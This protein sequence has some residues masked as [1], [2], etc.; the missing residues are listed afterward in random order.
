MPLH[1]IYSPVGTLSSEE[2]ALIAKNLT[3]VYVERGLPPFYVDV[4]F[5]DIPKDS[6]YVGGEQRTIVRVV[7]Q[8]LART[9][10]K[11]LYQAILD[12]V[13]GAFAPLFRERGLEWEFHIEQHERELWRIQGFNPPPSGSE[14]EKLWREKNRAVPYE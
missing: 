14:G 4:V 1:R 11:E 6:F 10:P 8:H 2:K 5:L 3:A 13:E 7:S 12:R 9:T